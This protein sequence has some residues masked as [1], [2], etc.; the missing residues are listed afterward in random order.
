MEKIKLGVLGISNH[1]IK[2]VFFPLLESSLI[3]V[4]ALASRS[5]DKARTFSEK[6]G[7][8]K[9]YG[10][11]EDLL[12]DKD[13]DAVYIPLPNHL[14]L[15]YIKKA[16]DA[17]KHILCE[18]PLTLSY[19]DTEEAVKYAKDKKVLLM[20]AFMY[21]FHSQ[22]LKAKE[23][24]ERRELGEIQTIHTYFSYNNPD[25]DNYRNNPDYGGGV[26]LDI[27]VYAVS[28]ARFLLGKEPDKVLAILERERFGVDTLVSGILYFGKSRSLFT[29]SGLTFPWQNIEV[30][31]TGGTLFIEV[32]FNTYPD[33]PAHVNVTTSI[34]QRTISLG[35]EDHYLLE[36]E[37]FANAIQRGISLKHLNEDSILN[38]KT[39][40]ALFLSAKEG[41]WVDLN[42]L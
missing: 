34:G 33:V 38:A 29:V 22:W 3:E 7:I 19:K 1:F 13:I 4:Y 28:T 10:S 11:Y 17:G 15:E 8:E 12:E 2:R 24:I 37:Y 32:P 40:D 21:K 31:G 41:R 26:L 20:E 30:Y 35:P 16:A 5:P 39:I 18:K 42:E 25:P 23:L 6:Y 27:G 36:F 14:H 9:W